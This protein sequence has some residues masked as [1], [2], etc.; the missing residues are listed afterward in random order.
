VK[1]KRGN[2]ETLTKAV[3]ER[4]KKG[5]IVA[6]EIVKNQAKALCKVGKYPAGSGKVGGALRQSIY[7]KVIDDA[8]RIGSNMEY[9]AT[10]EFGA[11]I[12]PYRAKALTIPIA[13]E[14][15][16]QRATDFK[17]LFIYENDGKVFLAKNI[18]DKTLKIYF[19]LLK[20]VDISKQPYLRPALAIKKKDIIKVL[21]A[22]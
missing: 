16:G 11:H 13:P 9:A 15:V 21:Q 12:T 7:S 18:N 1:A 3:I 2:I 10:I 17:D 6:G 19:M 5:L 14:A 4:K 22:A 20:S 8:V